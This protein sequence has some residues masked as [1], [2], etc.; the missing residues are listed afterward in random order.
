MQMKHI[1]D[2]TYMINKTNSQGKTLDWNMVLK[3]SSDK[4]EQKY[5][6]FSE[7]WTMQQGHFLTIKAF[8]L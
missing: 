8:Q 5:H 4:P 6:S 2:I 3:N 7:S 1:I